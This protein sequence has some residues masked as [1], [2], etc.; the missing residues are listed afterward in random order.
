MKKIFYSLLILS[1]VIISACHKD[2]KT[3]PIVSGPDVPGSTLDKIKDSIFLYAN[4]DYLW[5]TSLPSYISFQPRSK[6]SIGDELNK[7][8]QFA[9]NPAT[10]APYEYYDSEG[11]AKYS[12]IDS[13][14]V[15][16]E[17]N[18]NRGDYGFGILY[19]LIND[20]R[21]SYVYAGSPADQAGMKRGDEITSINGRTA[22]SYDH[23]QG[24]GDG[25][26]NNF[27]FVIDAYQ[28]SNLISMTL[29]RPDGSTY[30]VTNMSVAN[31]NVNPVITYKT[32]DE[33]GGKIVGYIVFNSFTSPNN[34]ETYLNEAFTYFAGANVTDL[35]VDLRYNGGGYVETAQYLDNLIVPAAKSGSLMFNTYYNDILSQNKEVLLK[36][37]WRKDPNTGTD[38]NYGP[39]YIDYSTAGNVANFQKLGTLNVN[40]VFFIITGHTASASELTINN[41]RPEMDVQ[42]IGETSYGK[43]VGFFDI[44]INKYTVYIPEFYTLNSANQGGYYAGFTPGTTDYPGIKDYDDLTKEFGDPTEGLLAHALHYVTT[45]TYSVKGQVIQSL[46]SKQENLS[47]EARNFMAKSLDMKKFTGMIG[48]KNLKHKKN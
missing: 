39:D 25:S 5:H 40:R 47:F 19:N 14:Q 22:I 15:A 36:N 26:S 21:V 37:Q 7:I 23:G 28:N 17:L 16:A 38:Y 35:V 41:L 18:G 29:Q 24:Y 3:G 9:I 33:G 31:Y 6:T 46:P 44:D 2:K 32:F 42:F 1:V 45:G 30:T 20:L 27:N 8:S 34:A 4:E 10:G 11:D 43:P 48:H 13:G 12:F